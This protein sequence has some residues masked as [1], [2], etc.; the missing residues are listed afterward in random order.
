MRRKPSSPPL[1]AQP[2]VTPMV[3][4]MLV[5]LIIF[6]VVTPSLLLGFVAD[7]P[8]GL[9]LSDHSAD[10]TQRVLGIDS[11][12]RYHLNKTPVGAAAL[13][14]RLDDLVAQRPDDRVLYVLAHR[15]LQ[16]GAVRDALAMASSS[17]FVVAGLIT[18]QS[19]AESLSP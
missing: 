12:G 7:P 15:S 8:E 16:Y 1:Q 10:G 17:G 3:D 4:V 5:L 2:N 13:A 6:M 14:A 18:E 11:Q 19:D 9:H